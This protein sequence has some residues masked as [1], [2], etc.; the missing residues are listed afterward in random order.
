MTK[1]TSPATPFFPGFHISTLSRKRRSQQQILKEN[2]ERMRQG[3]FHQ[4]GRM[5]Q[6]F[7]P[8]TLLATNEAGE[9]SRE[10]IFTKANTFFAFFGQILNE[11]KSCQGAVHR[12]REQA[13]AQE[14]EHLPSANT[15]SYTTARGR[16]KD[17]ELSDAFYDGAGAVEQDAPRRFGRPL[18]VAVAVNIVRDSQID[19]VEKGSDYRVAVV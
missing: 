7:L 12:I 8:D 14:A 1:N 4:L 18:I 2:R 9:N 10:R 13:Q 3:S 6:G 11:D 5:L 19:T 16:L 15:A 17:E